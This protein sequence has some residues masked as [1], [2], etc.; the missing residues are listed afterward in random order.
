M[1]QA[2]TFRQRLTSAA[3]AI[4]VQLGIAALL[5]VS[6]A[7]V[8]HVGSQQETILYLPQSAPQKPQPRQ[9]VV[10]D[11]R[12]R[13]DAA[14]PPSTSTAP[15]P[16]WATPGFALGSGANG[17]VLAQPPGVLDCRPQV[18]G[19][20]NASARTACPPPAGAAKPNPREIPLDPNKPVPNAKVWQA[21]IDRR[22]APFSVPGASGGL[23]GMGLTLLFNPGAYLDGRSYSYGAPPQDDVVDGAEMTHR[24]WSQIPQCNPQLDD[25]TRRNCAMMV[26]ATIMAGGGMVYPDHPHVTETAFR[27]ALAATQARTRSLYGAPVL[28]SGAKTGGGDAQIRGSDSGTGNGGAAAGGG[29]GR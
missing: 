2:A 23:L 13:A 20:L 17:I 21:E 10:I 3:A 1:M 6:F 9:P 12:P 22:N 26:D 4:G 8:R 15:L 18:Y 16:A 29:T 19:Y 25:T 24:A 5:A 11:A 14:P 27:Q 28:A 7:V